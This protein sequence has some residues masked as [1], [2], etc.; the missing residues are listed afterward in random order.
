MSIMYFYRYMYIHL[1]YS[2]YFLTN[3]ALPFLI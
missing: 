1:R 2:F 3:S